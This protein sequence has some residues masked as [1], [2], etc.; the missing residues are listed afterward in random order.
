MPSRQ[1]PEPV[2]E[3]VLIEDGRIRLLHRHLLRLHRAGAAPSQIEAVRLLAGAWSRTATAPTV[4][5]FDVAP[6]AMVSSAARAPASTDPVRLVTVSG[7][8]PDDRAR[9]QKRASRGWATDA[10]AEA[11][12]RDGDEPLL[13]SASGRLGETTRASLFLIDHSGRIATPPADGILPGVTR[14][15]VLDRGAR[16]DQPLHL[17]DLDAVRSA[18]ITSAGRGVVPVAAID[19]RPLVHDAAVGALAADWRALA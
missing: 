6:D 8:D 13:V 3:T 7:Y 18:F 2:L 17:D 11:V 5:R 19:G 16:D 9:E 15:W 10:E 12:R 4:V 1:L 14:S